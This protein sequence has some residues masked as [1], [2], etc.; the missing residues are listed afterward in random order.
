M[1]EV[2]SNFLIMEKSNKL[3]QILNIKLSFQN[4]IR[5]KYF[6]FKYRSTLLF[7]TDKYF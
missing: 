4:K 6:N 7:N 2:N 1:K 3:K 5:I